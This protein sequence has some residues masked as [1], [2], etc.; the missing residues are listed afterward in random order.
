MVGEGKI[1]KI[2]TKAKRAFQNIMSQDP[3][4]IKEND[5]FEFQVY[6]HDW[7]ISWEKGNRAVDLAEGIKDEGYYT[8][9][10]ELCF[11]CIERCFESWIMKK[12]RTKGFRAKHGDVFDLAASHNLITEKCAIGLRT[13]WDNYRAS[14]Y[15]RP[16]VPTK[17]SAERMI[18]LARTVSEFIDERL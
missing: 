13:L 10:I 15:Y 2:T 4:I 1:L 11:Y 9:S 17:K 6:K 5:E 16:Y 14:Q 12:K 18:E 3:N 7:K 8:V